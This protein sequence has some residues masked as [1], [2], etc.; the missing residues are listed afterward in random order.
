MDEIKKKASLAASSV[1]YLVGAEGRSEQ[2]LIFFFFF[3]CSVSLVGAH[4]LKGSI[5]FWTL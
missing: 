4:E 2:V 1:R 3:S 5:S